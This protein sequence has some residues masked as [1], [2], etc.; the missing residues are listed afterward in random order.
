M[1]SKVNVAET[2]SGRGI[3]L[4]DRSPPSDL[5]ASNTQS[6]GP[7]FYRAAWNADAV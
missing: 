3:L 1:C 6:P 5:T 2:F 7:D 4:M